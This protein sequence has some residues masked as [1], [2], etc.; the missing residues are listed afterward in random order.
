MKT[1][2]L[3]GRKFC[4]VGQRSLATLEFCQ[5][6]ADHLLGK[7]CTLAALSSNAEGLTD[8]AVTAAA[9]EDRI[10]DF[11]VSD[12][13]AKTNVHKLEPSLCIAGCEAD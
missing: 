5:R 9:F 8:I 10:A 11:A 4:G 1:V 7:A 3:S 12:A 13:K 6:F 2:Q